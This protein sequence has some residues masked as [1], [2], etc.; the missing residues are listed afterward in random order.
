MSTLTQGQFTNYQNIF[1]RYAIA[2]PMTIS[3]GIQTPTPST[4]NF[5]E[6]FAGANNSDT[7]GYPTTWYDFPALYQRDLDTFSRE[8]YGLVENQSGVIYLSP[9]Q[10]QDVFGSFNALDERLVVIKLDGH[11]F[12][13]DKLEYMEPLFGSCVAIEFT[14]KDA[15]RG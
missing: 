6:D 1:Y 13:L 7:D 12:M 10:I 15:V 14:L 3:L 2:S 4:G 5:L 9:I 8:R 11:I